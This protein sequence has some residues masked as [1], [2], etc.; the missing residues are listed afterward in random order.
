MTLALARRP[1]CIQSFFFGLEDDADLE[2]A[3]VAVRDVLRE[4]GAHVG[5]IN[6]MNAQRVLAMS[7][8]PSEG[9]MAGPLGSAAW[10]GTGA[11]YGTR[12]HVAATRALLRRRLRPHVHRLLFLDEALVRRVSGVLEHLPGRMSTCLA[13]TARKLLGGL[14]L[15]AGRPAEV[16]LPLAYWR[17]RV[18]PGARPLHPARSTGPAPW[19]C[20]GHACRRH[21]W[22][23]RP[24]SPAAGA[25]CRSAAGP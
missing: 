13:Q 19:G 22:G 5:G 8:P 11:L 10:T 9:R 18:E 14:E 6:L 21:L 12:Q 4:V 1:E 15:M 16:A 7:G 23:S 24:A 20:R 2:G 17:A 25:R 3:V